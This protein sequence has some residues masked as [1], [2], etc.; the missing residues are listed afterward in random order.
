[1]GKRSGFILKPFRDIPLML[2]YTHLKSGAAT[3]R[4]LYGGLFRKAQRQPG[5]RAMSFDEMCAKHCL[6]EQAL[7][8]KQRQL[9]ICAMIYLLMTVALVAYG[10]MMYHRMLYLAS[11]SCGSLAFMLLSFGF[12]EHFWYIQLKHKRLGITFY[13]W[14]RATIYGDIV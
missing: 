11:I 3:I 8:G 9:L 7:A 6:N 13:Q 12:R 1:M 10:V 2:G 4:F 5:Q 14:F